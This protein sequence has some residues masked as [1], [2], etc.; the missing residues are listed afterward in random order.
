LHAK[1]L[2][3]LRTEAG[4]KLLDDYSK[5]IKRTLPWYWDEMKGIAEGSEIE[6]TTVLITIMMSSILSLIINST[7]I[8]DTRFELSS[9]ADVFD[10]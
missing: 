2:P 8:K 4:L 5:L 1:I 10:Q 9:R 7:F 3:F 6:L